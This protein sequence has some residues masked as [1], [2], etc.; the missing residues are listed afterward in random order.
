MFALIVDKGFVDDDFTMYLFFKN[1]TM[2]MRFYPETPTHVDISDYGIFD[3]DPSTSNCYFN[4]N[5][6]SIMFVV[7]K[8]GNGGT[9]TINIDNSPEIM[10]SLHKCL[11]VWNAC[12]LDISSVEPGIYGTY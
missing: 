11:G 6:N 4:W 12:V 1:D 7:R 8:D 5:P 10:E 2:S 9:I 3:C